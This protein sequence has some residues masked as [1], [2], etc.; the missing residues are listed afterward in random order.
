V[1][2]ALN[3]SDLLHNEGLENEKGEISKAQDLHTMLQVVLKGLLKV[4]EEG[5]IWDLFYDGQLYKEV[6]LVPFIA[7]IKCDTSEADKFCGS[8]GVRNG[9]VAQLCRYCEC[10]TDESDNPLAKYPPKTQEKIQKLIEK[11]DEEGLKSLSQH[12]IN[13]AFYPFRFG[14][15]NNTGVHGATPVE[16]LHAILLG[17]FVYVRDIFFDAVGPSSQLAGEMDALCITYG[18]LLSRQSNRNL[19][20]TRFTN[21]IRA[22][23]LNG[24]RYTGVLLCMLAVLKSGEGSRRL[25][26]TRTAF[27]EHGYLENWIM[28]LETLLEWEAWLKSRK[29][30]RRHVERSKK[31]HRYIMYL[32]KTICPRNRGMGLKLMKFHAIMHYA[33]DILNFGVPYEVDT[34]SN[35]SHHKP[36]KQAALL[37]QKK[38]D[39]FEEQTSTRLDEV[40]LLDLA[41]AET[42]GRAI[43]YYS[44]GH[45]G[46]EVNNNPTEQV[47]SGKTAIGGT[48]YR[49]KVD[50]NGINGFAHVVKPKNPSYG[51]RM[52]QDLIDFVADL[53]DAVKDYLPSL[54]MSSLYT[55][56]GVTFRADVNHHGRLWRDWIL[57]DWGTY[58]ALPC[59]VYG[60]VNL[61]SLPADLTG[62]NRIRFGGLNNVAPGV[63]AIVECVV[64]EEDDKN[65][66]LMV[67]MT[68][69]VEDIR[70]GRVAELRFYLADAEAIMDTCIVVP[71]IGGP[72]NSYF[73]LKDPDDWANIFEKWLDAPHLDDLIETE[74]SEDEE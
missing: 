67:S 26:T 28:L 18:D 44:K 31:K 33:D 63:Y 61:G 12:Y 15:H 4:Q 53:Q 42:E 29:M 59:K 64:L 57:V 6:E 55:R 14:S 11:G 21:G 37:T 23:K 71:D 43:W 58:G 8:Y 69:E 19:P 47:V 20:L 66:D 72:P 38:K 30:Q 70:D 68:T 62:A 1:D 73:W 13:N 9:K 16:M 2:T 49:V 35:E 40:E 27:R 50:E 56:D 51:R 5:L 17:V 24:K 10:P 36:S 54:T 32:I 45:V 22:G 39:V 65:S 60:F 34:G 52:E 41:L 3:N 74:E 25:L 7:F 48:E 46:V